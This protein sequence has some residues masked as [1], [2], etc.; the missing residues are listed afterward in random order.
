[1]IHLTRFAA[2]LG[3]VLAVAAPSA[4]QDS[5]TRRVSLDLKAM[6]PADAFKVIADAVGLT[7]DVAGDVTTP[8]DIVVR[9]VTARTALNTICESI[10]CSWRLTGAAIAVRGGAG[11]ALRISRAERTGNKVA[12]MTRLSADRVQIRF[13]QK[14]VGDVVFKNAPLA[15]VAERL[16]KAAGVEITISGDAVPDQTFSADLSNRPLWSALTALSQQLGGDL[17][18]RVTLPKEGGASDE[19]VISIQVRKRAQQVRK[20]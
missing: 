2:A 15:Q 9:N 7:V 6:A 17:V 18:C 13:N 16:S 14:L 19:L 20:K 11:I 12:V 10:G 8:V 5:L 4:A 1:M 3:I